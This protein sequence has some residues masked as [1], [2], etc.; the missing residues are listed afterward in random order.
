[1]P[2]LRPSG[3]TTQFLLLLSVISVAGCKPAEPA[4]VAEPRRHT[5]FNL[6]T[7]EELSSFP[8]VYSAVKTLRASWLSG[9]GD[10]PRTPRIF[11][12]GILMP[13]IGALSA[14]VPREVRELRYLSSYEATNRYGSGSLGGVIE[15]ITRQ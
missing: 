6:L 12:D 15:I 1:M 13:N 4:G 9:R 8:D 14:I 2:F 7:A 3:I 10:P 11:L 5:S